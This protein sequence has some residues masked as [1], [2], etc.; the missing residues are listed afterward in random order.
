MSR[1]FTFGCSYTRYA[2]A[3]WADL[4]GVNYDDFYNL[5]RGGAS[6]TYIMNKFV[7]ADTMFNFTPDD[8]VIIMLTGIGRFSYYNRTKNWYTN[9]DL[10]EYY[11][12]TKDP[13]VKEFVTNMYSE[14]WAIYSAWIAA[15][16]MKTILT[17]KNVKHKLLMAINNRNYRR[18]DGCKW[19]EEDVITQI[20]KTDDLYRL[21]DVKESVDE[22][23]ERKQFKNKEYTLWKDTNQLDKH[24]TPKMHSMF[25]K[26]YLSEFYTDKS[27]KFLK[28]V[29]ANF[30]NT[31][32]RD[33]GHRFDV[34]YYHLNKLN[35]QPFF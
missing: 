33:Q 25:A 1:L 30:V 7:E 29:E 22:W 2:Y 34:M 11:H 9:G 15:N 26:E 28:E 18:P 17:S 13:A 23:M 20:A 31:S 6:N 32:Q 10:F 5:G 8:T 14:D 24:P 35:N 21:I 16:T 12:N 4:I 27:E 19:R 3:T